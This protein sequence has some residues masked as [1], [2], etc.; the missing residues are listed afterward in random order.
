MQALHIDADQIDYHADLAYQREQQAIQQLDAGDVLA[1]VDGWIA[2]ESDP[3]QHPLYALVL[4]ALDRRSMAG[5]PESLQ[6]RYGRMIDRAIEQLLED[7]LSHD[8]DDTL[9]ED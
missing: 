9:G 3:A 8:T 1:L 6:R 2:E 5:T 4:N 7:A